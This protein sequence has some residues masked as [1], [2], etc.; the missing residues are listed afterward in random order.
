[1][2]AL[3]WSTAIQFSG[4]AI[5]SA[6]VRS[7][8]VLIAMAT[9]VSSVVGLT[10]LGEGARRYVTGEFESLG[11]HLLVVLPGRN[12]T[13]GG[14][15]PIVGET[16]RDLTIAD[17][18]ALYRIPLV[19]KVA[20]ICVG[21]ALVSYR[22]RSRD[23]VVLGSTAEIE[24]IRHLHVEKGRFLPPGD[25]ERGKAVCVLGKTVREELFGHDPAI[26]QFIRIG[27]HRLRVIGLTAS[28]GES[29]GV[30]LDEVVIVPVSLAQAIFNTESLF[31][32]LIQARNGESLDHCREEV[33]RVIAARH[34]GERDVT[35]ITQDSVLSAF[36]R[37]FEAL[38]LTLAGI[39]MISLGVAGILIMNVMLV[40]VTQRTREIGLL[41]AIG[42]SPR[43]LRELILVEAVLLSLC[44]ALLGIGIGYLLS[45]L[46]RWYFPAVPVEPPI[47]A[48]IAATFVALS[49]GLIF[50][51]LPARRA[52][53]IDAVRALA[54]G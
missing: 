27:D 44:G 4:R 30:D 43:Q 37:I 24:P 18:T 54:E 42:A 10:A 22:G 25:P 8:F 45:A 29:I 28:Q 31:R 6:R 46:I 34:Q 50:A 14:M 12:E 9:S 38:T 3:R 21:E 41:K 51:W 7:I 48:V 53:R 17:A 35:V 36:D 33:E 52:S 13:T 23:E 5:L 20:P 32:I 11:L 2:N 40:A 19:D 15:P 49:T 26:G 1:M 16:P 47:W 39:A